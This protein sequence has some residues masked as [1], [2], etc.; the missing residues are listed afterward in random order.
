M[1]EAL[2]L[3]DVL[4]L[5][6]NHSALSNILWPRSTFDTS[7]EKRTGPNTTEFRIGSTTSIAKSKATMTTRAE[8]VAYEEELPLGL[9]ATIVYRVADFR[10]VLWMIAEICCCS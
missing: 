2:N 7:E 5:L 3:Q 9:S 6:H 1:P 8:G 10:R 4:M